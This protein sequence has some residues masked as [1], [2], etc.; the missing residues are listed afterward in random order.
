MQALCA[1]VGSVDFALPT[2]TDT[3]KMQA[4][5]PLVIGDETKAETA[6]PAVPIAKSKK[7]AASDSSS[8][9]SDD[10]SDEER[11]FSKR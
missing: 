10:S 9:D 3:K 4:D 5:K 11:D 2:L 6:S 8:S 1:Y 7:S